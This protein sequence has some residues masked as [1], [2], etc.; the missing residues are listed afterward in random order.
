MQ[1]LQDHLRNRAG[2][3]ARVYRGGAYRIRVKSGNQVSILYAL[4]EGATPL[5]TFREAYSACTPEAGIQ[6]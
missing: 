4:A 6:S 3:K 2:T 1:A 5:L